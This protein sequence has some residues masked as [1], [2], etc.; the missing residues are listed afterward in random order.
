[1]S[2]SA[3]VPSRSEPVAND[4][5]ITRVPDF[6]AVRAAAAPVLV[7]PPG[8]SSAGETGAGL[9]EPETAEASVSGPAAGAEPG[10]GD[11]PWVQVELSDWRKLT[12][13]GTAL[14]GR[15]PMPDG[16]DEVAQL[17]RVQDPGL[18]VSKTHLE[19]VVD[20]DGVWIVDRRST[21]GTIVTL[22][23]GQ[24]I[25]CVPGQ[26]VKVQVGARVSFG[27]F[28]LT[29]VDLAPSHSPTA[30]DEPTQV[31]PSREASV[32][33]AQFRTH[34]FVLETRA[35]ADISTDEGIR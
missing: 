26:R 19:I 1:M 23:D 2:I 18:S 6:R 17:V 33:S 20:G 24:Q 16:D 29:V 25:I 5:L 4:D 12:I 35:Q 21:N 32:A 27:D 9:D 34:H 30:Y 3:A 13:R 7:P 15:N 22:A 11:S 31:R 14:F 28:A 10:A 8:A